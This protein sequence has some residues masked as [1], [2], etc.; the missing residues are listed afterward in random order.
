[1]TAALLLMMDFLL[2]LEESSFA[3]LVRESN[4]LLAY[5]SMLF[6]HT[7]GM[8]FLA[9]ISILVALRILGIAS[10]VPLG[11]LQKL[12]PYMWAGFW[13]NAITG[14]VLF[15][16]DAIAKATNPVFYTKLGFIAAAVVA[17]RLID[18][19]RPIETN[20]KILAFATIFCWIGAITAGRLLAY[21]GPGVEATLGIR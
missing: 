4:S 6:L 8:G 1:M 5:P 3:T 10:E 20:G 13:V 9:G 12:L 15:M 11:S 2:Q 17:M 18:V 7:L 19:D 21:V 14:G 16:T